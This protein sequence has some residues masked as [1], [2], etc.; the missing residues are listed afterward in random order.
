MQVL[1]QEGVDHRSDHWQQLRRREVGPR[2]LE[3]RRILAPGRGLDV[4]EEDRDQ[5]VRDACDRRAEDPEDPE[6]RLLAEQ[7]R[8]LLGTRSANATKPSVITGASGS[9]SGKSGGA[10]QRAQPLDAE[11]RSLG[12]LLE[13]H[14]PGASERQHR[15]RAPGAVPVRHQV[16]RAAP[17]STSRSISSRRAG[18][19]PLP[20]S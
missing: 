18:G 5:G 1:A 17:H 7:G 3:A 9:G 15:P 6:N 12:G 8:H 14:R 2:D 20:G 4:H 10:E 19:S 16:L 11:A 13:R